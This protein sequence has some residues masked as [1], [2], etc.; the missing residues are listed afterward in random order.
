[1]LEKTP[2]EIFSL[3]Q[4][5]LIFV[6]WISA[7]LRA[8]LEELKGPGSICFAKMWIVENTSLAPFTLLL[9]VAKRTIWSRQSNLSTQKG[10]ARYILAKRYAVH[11]GGHADQLRS[12]RALFKIAIEP[13]VAFYDHL[14]SM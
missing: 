10:Q 1:L 11:L 8:P 4:S 6:N 7:S 2:D 3:Y 9:Q 12:V 5:G 14:R 13:L